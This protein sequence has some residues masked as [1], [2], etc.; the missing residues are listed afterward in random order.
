MTVSAAPTPSAPAPP[1][2]AESASRGWAGREDG[3]LL[4]VI[5][6][7]PADS[8]SRAAA[9]EVLVSRYES[10]VRS[11]AR[12]Y[13]ASPEPAEELMQV[14]YVGLMKAINRF[15]PGVGSSLAPYAMACVS[16]EIKRHFRDKRWQVHVKR[17]AQELV[18]ELRKAAGELGHQLGHAPGD[19][20]LAEHLQVSEA[21]IRDARQAD[22]GA[23]AWSLDA[24]AAE[25]GGSAS[26]GDLLGEE[27]PRVE[28]TLDMAA[29]QQHWSDLPERER[30]ILL[31]R[32]YGNMTQSEIGEQL[33]L[34][35]MHVSR[36]LSQSLSYL[37][38]CLLGP[39]GER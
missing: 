37:R 11:C 7:E 32:F 5:H 10:L 15:D 6:A 30:R 17:S 28:H 35:Q 3:E 4:R 1:Q 9:C 16:G 29:L 33:G 20:D 36:L 26:M 34:S 25:D 14:G 13:H 18:L 19:A 8:A 39:E 21:A 23:Q 27:D 22:L 2:H 38:G 24:P 31:M 12:K